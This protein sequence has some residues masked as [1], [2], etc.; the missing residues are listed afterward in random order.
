MSEPKETKR[1]DRRHEIKVDGFEYDEKAGPRGATRRCRVTDATIISSWDF[2]RLRWLTDVQ[3]HARWVLKDGSLGKDLHRA[4]LPWRVEDD[5]FKV[6][7]DSLRDTYEPK[8]FITF[9]EKENI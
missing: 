2:A 7:G 9:I 4:Y 5:R 6:L 8:T 1:F 3:L